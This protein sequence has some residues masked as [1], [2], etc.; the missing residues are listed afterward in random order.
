MKRWSILNFTGKQQ[1]NSMNQKIKWLVWAVIVLFLMNAVTL[2]TILYHNYK[3]D[4]G[5][6]TT[7]IANSFSGNAMNGRFFRQA[8]G[9]ND[10]QMAVFQEANQRFRP[11]TMALTLSIDSLKSEMFTEMKKQAADTMKLDS[12][13]KKVGDLHGQLKHETY[14]FYLKLKSVCSQQQQLELDKVFEPLF[15][16]EDLSTRPRGFQRGWNRVNN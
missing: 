14:Q 3:Q 9:F 10:D 1:T 2:G 15:I 13:S 11:Q 4:R 5:I 8:L 7:S 16:N 12:L 6:D